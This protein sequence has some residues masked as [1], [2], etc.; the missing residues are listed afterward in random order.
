MMPIIDSWILQM[1]PENK[2]KTIFLNNQKI[3]IEIRKLTL[4]ENHRSYLDFTICS[5][6]VL[7]IV[8]EKSHITDRI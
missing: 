7:Y 3:I 1:F 8:T 2:K 6:N 4:I 5:N